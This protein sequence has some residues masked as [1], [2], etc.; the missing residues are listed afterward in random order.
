MSSYDYQCKKCGEVFEYFS[1]KMLPETERKP[2]CPKCGNRNK[3]TMEYIYAPNPVH[4]K[5]TGWTNKNFADNLT[6]ESLQGVKRVNPKP[7]DEILYKK[8]KPRRW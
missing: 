2:K 5:G 8:K 3:K 6:P 7:G 4:F 1:K